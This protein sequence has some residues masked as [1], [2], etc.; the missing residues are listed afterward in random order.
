MAEHLMGYYHDLE[1]GDRLKSQ[2]HDHAE[3]QMGHHKHSG[4]AADVQMEHLGQNRE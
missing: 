2:D 4:L 3:D 1:L